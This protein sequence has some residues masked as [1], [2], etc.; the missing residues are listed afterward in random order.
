V[1][2]QQHITARIKYKD[3]V[4]IKADMGKGYTDEDR[5]KFA[6]LF[7]KAKKGKTPVGQIFEVYALE[8]GSKGAL[9]LPKVGELRHDKKKADC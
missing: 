8:E 2:F 5:I 4:E 7:K 9:R 6:K 3:G 1:L